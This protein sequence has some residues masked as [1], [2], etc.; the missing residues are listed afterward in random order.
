MLK[1]FSAVK[2][3]KGKLGFW[4]KKCRF[5]VT[6]AS[7]PTHSVYAAMNASAVLKPLISYLTPSSNGIRKSSSTLVKALAKLM[8]F[9]KSL[10]D[11][12]SLTSSIIVRHIETEYRGKLSTRCFNSDLQLSFLE[13]PIAKIYSLASRTKCKLLLPQFFSCLAQLLDNF[14][15]AHALKWGRFSGYTFAQ[16]IPEFFYFCFFS[17]HRSSPQFKSTMKLKHC[18]TDITQ[19]YHINNFGV[20]RRGTKL[21]P[22]YLHTCASAQI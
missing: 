13:S 2:T 11:K 15:F 4:F 8:K 18:Q 9:W 5:S 20:K 6:R 21:K 1:H 14:L 17:F 10:G 22:R 16:L 19:L 3:L 12:L 7:A